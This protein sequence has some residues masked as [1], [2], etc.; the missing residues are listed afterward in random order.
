MSVLTCN[1]QHTIHT[2][3]YVVHGVIR[4]SSTFNTH[5]IEHLYKDRHTAGASMRLIHLHPP[6]D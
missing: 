2:Q 6:I 4:R 5:R 1:S 3:G